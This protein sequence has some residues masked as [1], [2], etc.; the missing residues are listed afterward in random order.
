MTTPLDYENTQSLN[1][2]VVTSDNGKPEPLSTKLNLQI[3]VIDENDNSPKFPHDLVT[4]KEIDLPV[5]FTMQ[6]DDIFIGQFKANDKDSSAEFRN[7]SYRVMSAMSREARFDG[8]PILLNKN[9]LVEA[10]EDLF[11]INDNGS[12][13][14][15]GNFLN[16]TSH[17][18]FLIQLEA[19]DQ[20]NRVI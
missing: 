1:L 3:K 10:K 13:I 4:L 7:T 17:N 16:V 6:S 9:M 14:L 12:L 18:Y 5:N 11:Q 8:Q 20:E 19:F 2:T 15:T